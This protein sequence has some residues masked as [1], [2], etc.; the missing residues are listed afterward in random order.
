MIPTPSPRRTWKS[1]TTSASLAA[2]ME[3]EAAI[4][5][6][7]AARRE[8]EEAFARV[9]DDAL[10]YLKPGDDYALGG[11][12]VHVNWVLARYLQVLESGTVAQPPPSAERLRGGLSPAE[13]RQSLAEMSRLHEAVKTRVDRLAESDWSRKSP[14]VYGPGEDPYPTSPE[15]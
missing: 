6:F 5:D 15:D 13:R 10:R 11:L 4:A 7:D 14:V 2:S 9:P 1:T 8:W 3:R 12:Q